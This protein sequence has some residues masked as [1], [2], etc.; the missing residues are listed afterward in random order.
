VGLIG[1]QHSVKPGEKLLGTVVSVKDD[2]AFEDISQR[3][4]AM[5]IEHI[6]AVTLRNSPYMLGCSDGTYDASFLFTIGKTFSCKVGSAALRGLNDDRSLD[7][8]SR[9]KYSICS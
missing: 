5:I 4:E 3:S 8:T 9:L 6:H 7:V 1:L 2:G